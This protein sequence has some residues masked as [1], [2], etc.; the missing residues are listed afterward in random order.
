MILTLLSTEY[1]LQ[2]VVVKVTNALKAAITMSTFATDSGTTG[3]LVV[4]RNVSGIWKSQVIIPMSLRQGQSCKQDSKG[5]RS[6][7]CKGRCVTDDFTLPFDN[8]LYDRLVLLKGKSL[9]K[10]Q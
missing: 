3:S 1:H 9:E 8:Y 4:S 6:Q 5:K 7:H 2:V 10:Q